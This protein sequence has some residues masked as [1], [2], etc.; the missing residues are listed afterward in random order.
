MNEKAI[1]DKLFEAG[2]ESSLPEK[3]VMIER[4]GLTFTIRALREGTIEKLRKRYRETKRVRGED[5][6]K[7]DEPRFN[8]ALIDAATVAIGGNS[9]ITWSHPSLIEKYNVSGAEQVIKRVLLSGEIT[10]LGS[11]VLEISG[12][13]D[14]AKEVEEIKNL[15][16]KED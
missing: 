14:E 4:T 12:Y 3:T 15:L 10:Q 5:I 16:E 6:E 2:E 8:R 13:Y 7:T 1:L 11:I 9:A